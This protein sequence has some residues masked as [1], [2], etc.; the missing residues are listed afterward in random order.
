M[1]DDRDG[2]ISGGACLT[3]SVAGTGLTQV[4]ILVLAMGGVAGTGVTEVLPEVRILVM[5]SK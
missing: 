1:N 3:V 4:A 5:G 2:S